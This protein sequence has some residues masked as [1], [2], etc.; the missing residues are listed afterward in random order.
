MISC[1][2][3]NALL[4]ASSAPESELKHFLLGSLPAWQVPRVWNFVES[5]ETNARGKLSRSEWRRRW[6]ME[7]VS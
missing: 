3:S 2:S 5:L 4:V 6:L 1:W 7:V